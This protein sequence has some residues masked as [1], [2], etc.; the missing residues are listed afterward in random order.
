M[1]ENP[2]HFQSWPSAKGW[3]PPRVI[4][5]LCFGGG[6][7][8]YHCSFRGFQFFFLTWKHSDIPRPFWKASTDTRIWLRP[9][10][11]LCA[12]KCV[13]YSRYPSKKLIWVQEWWDSLIMYKFLQSCSVQGNTDPLMAT[14]LAGTAGGGGTQGWL[15]A[16]T[17]TFLSTQPQGTSPESL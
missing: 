5:S 12:V 10:N 13:M 7:D 8:L 2:E 15:W 3:L 14:G 1:S 17:H 11:F 4:Q 6:F 9:P 16:V